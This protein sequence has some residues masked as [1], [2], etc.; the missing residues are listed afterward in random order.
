[1]KLT[2]ADALF[3]QSITQHKHDTSR[4]TPFNTNERS[5]GG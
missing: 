3:I 1:M 5:K 4:K 2:K